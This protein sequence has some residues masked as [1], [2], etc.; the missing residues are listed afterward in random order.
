MH[1]PRAGADVWVSAELGADYA[2][3]LENQLISGAGSSGQTLGLRNVSGVTAVTHTNG[4]EERKRA[5]LVADSG[6]D[7]A[8]SE[9]AST[10]SEPVSATEA[11][12][13]RV[14]PPRLDAW[15]LGRA[16]GAVRAAEER[17]RQA[18][19]ARAALDRPAQEEPHVTR[20]Y[21][22]FQEYKSGAFG[23]P[24]DYAVEA[25]RIVE[26]VEVDERTDSHRFAVAGFISGSPR[27]NR[28]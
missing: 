14:S 2:T 8:V 24:R 7:S 23:A 18:R 12:S 19:A 15:A 21:S 27:F 4:R 11:A 16:V 22:S 10:V 9:L 25:A 13:D 3:K 5:A 26:R 17:L 20:T 28:P 6:A 1:S